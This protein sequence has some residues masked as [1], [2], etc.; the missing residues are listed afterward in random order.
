MFSEQG[1]Q[2]CVSLRFVQHGAHLY[3]APRGVRNESSNLKLTLGLLC[4]QSEMLINVYV[5]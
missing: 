1:A 4:S 2:K 5:L 3:G